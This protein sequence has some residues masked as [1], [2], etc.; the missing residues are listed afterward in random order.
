MAFCAKCGSPMP[1][2]AGFCASC[3]TRSG[4]MGPG[5]GSGLPVGKTRYCKKCHVSS[6]IDKIII[7]K[8]KT[9]ATG[10]EQFIS[11]I[12]ILCFFFPWLIY[13]IYLWN[14]KIWICPNCDAKEA[15]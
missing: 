6:P 12:L 13:G 9:F 7:Q 10:W 8:G 11:L 2:G 1:A 3:G 15:L 14:R 5:P 4:E